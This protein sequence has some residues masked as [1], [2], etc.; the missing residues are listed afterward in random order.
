M[1]KVDEWV[2][3][4]A[5]VWTPSLSTVG[6]CVL[7]PSGCMLHQHQDCS[8]YYRQFTTKY[9]L[10]FLSSD[11]SKAFPVLS[12]RLHD[13]RGQIPK[14]LS[15][16][17]VGGVRRWGLWDP[18]WRRPSRLHR[19]ALWALLVSVLMKFEESFSLLI[20]ASFLNLLISVN[21]FFLNFGTKCLCFTLLIHLF[22]L[23]W[24]TFN[25]LS[26][27]V[28]TSK[29]VRVTSELIHMKIPDSVSGDSDLKLC[30]WS[31]DID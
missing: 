22:L 5:F 3:G 20:I 15:G 30:G 13:I 28:L 11:C 9:S 26:L 2:T 31:T 4:C 23:L 25:F 17:L 14:Q 12:T 1:V 8:L 10:Q 21:A 24:E 19:T 18:W 6:S 7:Y 16:G 29:H 27:W